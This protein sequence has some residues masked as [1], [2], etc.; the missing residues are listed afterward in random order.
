MASKPKRIAAELAEL[1]G[2]DELIRLRRTIRRA[3]RLEGFVAG[4]GKEWIL[5]HVLN[6]D[7]FLDGY[8]ALRI[9]DLRRL[10]RRGGPESFPVRALRHF[11]ETPVVANGVDLDSIHGVVRSLAERL[12]LV[13]IN[14][15]HF[16][17]DVCWVGR[18]ARVGKRRLRL[19][20]IHPDAQWDQVPTKWRL[21]RITRVDAGGRYLQAL[22]A[23]GGQTARETEP[24]S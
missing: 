19:L 4:V 14:M 16:D 22:H 5:V 21:D 6:P 8:S 7:M 18:P 17:P 15:E 9:A 2:T 10:E 11:G 24:D 13:A 20:E 3:D 1:V 12:P 23:V